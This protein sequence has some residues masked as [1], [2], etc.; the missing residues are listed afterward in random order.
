MPNNQ[1]FMSVV[2]KSDSKKM[3]RYV[4]IYLFIYLFQ[5]ISRICEGKREISYQG[6]KQE[7]YVKYL[8]ANR[9]H[10]VKDIQSLVSSL[11]FLPHLNM[12][13]NRLVTSFRV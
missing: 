3:G 1:N 11:I 10:C 8:L 2:M 7:L 5:Y 9:R 4:Y 6:G 13:L 12:F